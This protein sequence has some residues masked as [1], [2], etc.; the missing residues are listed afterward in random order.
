MGVQSE[1][2]PRRGARALARRLLRFYGAILVG[3]V[4][5]YLVSLALGRPLD[6]TAAALAFLACSIGATWGEVK[7]HRDRQHP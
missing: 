4:L 3:L 5:C 1:E 6:P 2:Q 7:R